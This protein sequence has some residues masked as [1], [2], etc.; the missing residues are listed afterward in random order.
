MKEKLDTILNFLSSCVLKLRSNSTINITAYPINK[1]N[2]TFTSRTHEIRF[3]MIFCSF[4][5]T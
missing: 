5:A 1:T 2:S 4:V 3:H